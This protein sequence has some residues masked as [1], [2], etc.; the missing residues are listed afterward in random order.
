MPRKAILG[1]NPKFIKV[2]VPHE[3]YIFLQKKAEKEDVELAR[4]VR[5]ILIQ[6]MKGEKQNE[7]Q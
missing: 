3:L 6:A 7:S 4:V 2:L 1:D 5:K